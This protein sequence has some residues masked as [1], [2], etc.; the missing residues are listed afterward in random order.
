MIITRAGRGTNHWT[1]DR[2]HAA[3]I[4]WASVARVPRASPSGRTLMPMFGKSADASAA[5]WEPPRRL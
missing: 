2:A 1:R 3:P 4:R 5:N